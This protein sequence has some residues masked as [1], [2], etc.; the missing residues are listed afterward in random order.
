VTPLVGVPPIVE[1]ARRAL[2]AA[3]GIGP[4]AADAMFDA[5]LRRTSKKTFDEK[6]AE[7]K[8]L[9]VMH[10]LTWPPEPPA[11]EPQE[12]EEEA[13]SEDDEP[14]AEPRQAELGAA[15][16]IPAASRQQVR[17][18]S[19][20]PGKIAKPDAYSL[21]RDFFRVPNDAA[22]ELLAVMPGPV[23][24]A[25]VYAHRLAKS[26]GTFWVSAGG[27][28]NKIGCRT[29]RHGQRVVE[30][31]MAAGLWRLLER[32]GP[33]G[34]KANTYQLVQPASLD[35]DAVREALSRPLSPHQDSGPRDRYGSGP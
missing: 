6:I 12:P 27:L 19:K 31:L 2:A 15:G 7:A 32:G 28:A 8:K 33:A 30:R 25:Y 35:L 26:D 17:S 34:S 11:E 21:T 14:Q 4:D 16:E 18:I 20:R 24:K 10:G 3:E 29:Q 13:R 23:L 22:D 9:L 5:L 1:D